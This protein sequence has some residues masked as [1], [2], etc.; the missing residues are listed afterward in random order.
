M[1]VMT[2]NGRRKRGLDFLADLFS[3][4]VNQTLATLLTQLGQAQRRIIE[5]TATEQRIENAASGITSAANDIQAGIQALKDRLAALEGVETEDLS[6]ELNDLD[7]AV[8]R[9]QSV[10]TA[11]GQAHPSGEDAAEDIAGKEADAERPQGRFE[12]MSD[13]E[14]DIPTLGQDE[15]PRPGAALKG[16]EVTTLPEQPSERDAERDHPDATPEESSDP[17]TGYPYAQSPSSVPM[18]EGSSDPNKD[19]VST[20]D[21]PGIV[22]GDGIEGQLPTELGMPDLNEDAGADLREDEDTSGTL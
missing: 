5:M 17:V 15:P 8:E 16:E 19:A 2:I 11:L 1:D 12:A 13:P 9:L 7:F 10:G 22:M 21:K 14:Q 18:A 4:R 20:F 3:G 6:Q